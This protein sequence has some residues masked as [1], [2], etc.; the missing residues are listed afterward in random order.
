[1]PV[2]DMP[3][4]DMPLLDMPLLDMPLLDMPV[5]DMP[6]LDMS[7]KATILEPQIPALRRYAFGLTRDHAAADDLVQDCL[8]RA[9]SRWHLRP[10]DRD[11]RPWLFTILH[12]LFI[13]ALRTQRR[14]PPHD[15][16]NETT[17]A[18]APA[19]QE[20]ALMGRDLCQQFARL[21]PDHQ[22]V[23]LLVGVEGLA[24]DAVGRV[25]GV[26]VG[27]VMSRL[28]RAREQFRRLLDGERPALRRVK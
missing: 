13:S 23:L 11:V 26:P 28:S 3:V 6:V 1:M 18:A 16:L 19:D 8:E 9:V 5:L 25:L 4:L 2:L 14:R 10:L 12:N 27:T 22:S 15:T 24:Y 20:S 7:D 17:D 21:S